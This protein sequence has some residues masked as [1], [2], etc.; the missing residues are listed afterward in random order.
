VEAKTNKVVNMK[1][2]RANEGANVVGVEGCTVG[3]PR[4]VEEGSDELSGT[5][6]R[7]MG[8]EKVG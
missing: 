7:S 6:E 8:E 5:I 4:D 1:E 2:S 3:I